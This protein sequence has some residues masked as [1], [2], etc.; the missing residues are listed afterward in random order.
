M[1]PLKEGHLCLDSLGVHFMD[2]LFGSKSPLTWFQFESRLC[3]DGPL[4]S[5]DVPRGS[6]WILAVDVR[7]LPTLSFTIMVVVG[8]HFT[9]L[10]LW[11]SG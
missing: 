6:E 9:F 5:L 4:C 7:M 10:F 11:F 3:L 2:G 1:E 8:K